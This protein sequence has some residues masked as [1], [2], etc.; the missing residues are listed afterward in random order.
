MSFDQHHPTLQWQ[1]STAVSTHRASLMPELSQRFKDILENLG[2]DSSRPGLVDTPRRAAQALLF[3]TKGYE[4]NIEHAV[5]NAV[6]E[7]NHDE[8]VSST[9]SFSDHILCI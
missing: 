4:D 7:E 2:E 9:F 5:K 8:M 6:F 3:F 1:Q